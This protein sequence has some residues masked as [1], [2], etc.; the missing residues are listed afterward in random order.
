MLNDYI[1]LNQVLDFKE[2]RLNRQKA[3][4][5]MYKVPI[6]CFTLNTPGPYKRFPLVDKTFKEGEELI[7][8]QLRQYNIKVI[9]TI[10][11]DDPAGL[12]TI[13][14]VDG[15]A[16]FIKEI[17][18]MIEEGVSIGRLFDIDV[19]DLNL[20]HISRKELG[21][22]KR[23][24]LLCNK[25]AFI[26]SR[27]RAHSAE[28]LLHEITNIMEKYFNDKYADTISSYAL[29]ALI[30]EVAVTPKPGL[31]DRNDTGSH[32]DM[33]IF[34]FI[35][36]S[37]VLTPFFRQFV[38]K[39]IE[40]YNKPLN[41]LL[42]SIRYIGIRAEETMYKATKGVNTHKGIIFSLGIICSGL[43][44][45]YKNEEPVIK[46]FDICSAISKDI[47]NELHVSDKDILSNGEFE[48]KRYKS[49]GIRGEASKG[50]P[51]V[52]NIGLPK[53]KEYA[54]KGYSLNDAGAVT[55]LHLLA[56]VED[57][58]TLHRS[59][60]HTLKS[61]QDKVSNHLSSKDRTLEFDLAFIRNLNYDFIINNIS[62]GGCADLLAI[63]FMLYFL[64][65]DNQ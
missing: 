6:I 24:C 62:P 33:D 38:L 27:S 21:K 53:L 11:T 19:L 37:S 45:L 17:L 4:I 46:I 3:A 40:S 18:I 20:N 16:L 34:T 51:S 32:K 54:S 36:S 5:K 59:N 56:N 7:L 48:F 49:Q 50:F 25:D 42:S 55:L 52:K 31:V 14:S 29:R 41:K 63:T 30:S 10:K 57:T 2:N 1:K 23:K 61:I 12:E 28:E 60:M 9:N 44:Y 13:Y 35:K 22:E 8:N 65:E 43:G 64:S 47:I 39:G 58:N 15:D 26:C